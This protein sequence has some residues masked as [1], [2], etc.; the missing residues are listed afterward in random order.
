MGK[1]GQTV[2]AGFFRV[3]VSAI[4]ENKEKRLENETAVNVSTIYIFNYYLRQYL[5][6]TNYLRIR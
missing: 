1:R 6:K 5:H 2:A 4:T 3:I